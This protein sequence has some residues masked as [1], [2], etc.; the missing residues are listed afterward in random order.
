MKELERKEDCEADPEQTQW[1]YVMLAENDEC[2]WEFQAWDKKD[3]KTPVEGK[4]FPTRAI[5]GAKSSMNVHLSNT[6]SPMLEAIADE[7]VDNA[8]V[9]STEHALFKIDSYNEEK[10]TRTETDTE[11][12]DGYE[13]DPEEFLDEDDADVFFFFSQHHQET[14]F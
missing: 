14:F 12:D 13:T 1:S 8:E 2:W 4:L 11:S 3:H 9:I 6:I 7:M 5:I 10:E